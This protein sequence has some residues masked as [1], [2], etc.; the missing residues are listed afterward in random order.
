MNNFAKLLMPLTFLTLSAGAYADD[1]KD[2]SGKGK[3]HDRREFKEE[4]WDG[5][6]KV[7][8][9]MKHGEYK[10]KRKC[11][12]PKYAS[13]REYREVIPVY[14]DRVYYPVERYVEPEVRY[15]DRRQ[16]GVSIDVSIRR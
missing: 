3:R 6:C 2:E 10:E 15:Y 9:K 7:E 14:E 13:H 8:R 5:N 1:W 12:P 11:K 4:Y 16:P